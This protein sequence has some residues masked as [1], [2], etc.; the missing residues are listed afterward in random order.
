MGYSDTTICII[1]SI[2]S[3]LQPLRRSHLDSL[4]AV[5]KIRKLK[6]AATAEYTTTKNLFYTLTFELL[7]LEG[8]HNG[9]PVSVSKLVI[10]IKL[11][12][13][14]IN[15]QFWQLNACSDS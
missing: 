7:I 4:Q 13:S 3:D 14:I 2:D 6:L 11:R 1:K 8:E 9:Y 12:K 5:L 10:T 15:I